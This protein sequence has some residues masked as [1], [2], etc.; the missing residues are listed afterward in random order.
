MRNL[1]GKKASRT[2]LPED[3]DALV[4]L[5]DTLTGDP[6]QRRL[7]I[8]KAVSL[9]PGNLK[10]QYALLMLGSLGTGK[11]GHGEFSQI[12][13][14]ILT[15]FERPDDFEESE[16]RR[17]I[18]EIF[19][20]P[21]LI[22]C[23]EAAEDRERFLRSYLKDLTNEYVSLFIRDSAAHSGAFLG[24]STASSRLRA[25]SAP[26][27]RMLSG[28]SRCP[29]LDGGERKL[30][31]EALKGAAFRAVGG[32]L[33]LVLEALDEPLKKELSEDE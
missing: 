22:R 13:S 30:L 1:F 19:D 33:S 29:Y 7:L 14:Y 20:H 24:F 23:L 26:L 27:A 10:A 16:K 6:W 4:A 3:P 32:D 15:P 25:V 18:R 31:L 12:K 11:R 9:S 2:P 21:L 17:M 5:S 8:E 28:V